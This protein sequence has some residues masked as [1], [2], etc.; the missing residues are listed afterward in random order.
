MLEVIIHM[1]SY[2]DCAQCVEYIIC[3]YF[4]SIYTLIKLLTA[5]RIVNVI[6]HYSYHFVFISTDCL[7]F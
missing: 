7:E 4:L 1:I 2:L 6:L 3:R 5:D